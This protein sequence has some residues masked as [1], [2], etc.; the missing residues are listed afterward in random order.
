[1]LE[2]I[3]IAKLGGEGLM[4]AVVLLLLKAQQRQTQVLLKQ[5]Q[6][7]ADR[8]I[9][10]FQDVLEKQDRQN[11]RNHEAFREMLE[12]VQFTIG[13]IS[14]LKSLIIRWRNDRGNRREYREQSD[15]AE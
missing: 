11:T 15:S 8:T 9:G 13:Q 10:I 5:Q 7:F 12:H 1:M 2:W 6:D 14:E 4:F 3:D